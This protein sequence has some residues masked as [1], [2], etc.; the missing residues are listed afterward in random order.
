MNGGS[1][2]D[3]ANLSFI[4]ERLLS[5][6]G[7]CDISA[8]LSMSKTERAHSAGVLSYCRLVEALLS[9]AIYLSFPI[10]S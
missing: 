3:S 5:I 1:A 10:D 9:F 6:L 2:S 7:F 4:N 8:Q